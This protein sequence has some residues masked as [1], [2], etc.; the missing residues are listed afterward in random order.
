MSKPLVISVPHHLSRREALRRLKSGLA[1]I[2]R[3]YAFIFTVQEQTWIDYHLQFRISVLGQAAC[4]SI[5][6]TNH[7][8]HLE[9]FLPWLLAQLA[10]AAEPIIRRQ[11]ALMLETK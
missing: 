1:A 10:E 4:G 2:E 7:Q 3:D 11:G 5:D 9:A 8:V 6:V